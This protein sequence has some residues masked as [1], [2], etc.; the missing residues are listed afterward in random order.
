[1][2][3]ITV[4]GWMVVGLFGAVAVGIVNG[5]IKGAVDAWKM[6]PSGPLRAENERVHQEN[7]DLRRERDYYMGLL[8]REL[9]KTDA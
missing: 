3:P 6:R 9:R 4:L 8:E 1:M 7:L 2:S 5:I